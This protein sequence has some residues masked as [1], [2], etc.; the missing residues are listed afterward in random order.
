MGEF[1]DVVSG[2]LDAF[3]RGISIIKTQRG[4]RKSEKIPIDPTS[5]SAETH[6]TKTLKYNRVV[7]EDAYGKDLVRHGP[8]FAK[9]DGKILSACR[10]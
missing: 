1:H 6:L 10:N 2:L 5:K 4:R 8:E 3:A 7:V 9:G